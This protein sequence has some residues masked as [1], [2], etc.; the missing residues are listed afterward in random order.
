MPPDP[1]ARRVNFQCLSDIWMV[2]IDEAVQTK[3]D[4]SNHR[5]QC[6]GKPVTGLASFTQQKQRFD[7]KG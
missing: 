4:N 3:F 5:F 7:R 1:S 2:W 6:P